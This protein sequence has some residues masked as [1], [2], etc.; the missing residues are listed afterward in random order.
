MSLSLEARGLHALYFLMRLLRRVYYL[1]NYAQDD[2]QD[3]TISDDESV[4]GPVDKRQSVHSTKGK[5]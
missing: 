4:T 2:L 1:Y 5:K 3:E